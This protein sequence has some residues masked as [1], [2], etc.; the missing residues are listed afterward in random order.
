LEST[1]SSCQA[2]PL[3]S[4]ALPA[5][6]ILAGVAVRTVMK[7]GWSSIRFPCIFSCRPNILT[8]K[9]TVSEMILS[10]ARLCSRERSQWEKSSGS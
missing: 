2:V 1:A 4:S 3:Y 5:S 10:K 6:D 7:T 9:I 8:K